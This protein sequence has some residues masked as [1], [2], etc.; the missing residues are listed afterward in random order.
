M[1]RVVLII[2][3]AAALFVAGLTFALSRETTEESE[4]VTVHSTTY[5][6]ELVTEP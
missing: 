6:L 5:V 1:R 3:A 4:P 2:G